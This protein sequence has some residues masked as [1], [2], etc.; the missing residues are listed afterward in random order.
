MSGIIANA[1]T[2]LKDL[3]ENLRIEGHSF[4][5]QDIENCDAVADLIQELENSVK[6][7]HSD[8]ETETI[9]TSQYRHKLTLIR[10]DLDK[11][12]EE[13]VEAARLSH[14][15]IM[16]NL[17]Q[18]L[19]DINISMSDLHS[20]DAV[21]AKGIDELKPQTKSLAA[22]HHKVIQELNKK[23]A[24]KAEAQIRVNE[25]ND[26]LAGV[27]EKIK[28]AEEAILLLKEQVNKVEKC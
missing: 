15:H 25:T 16:D 28:E 23:M 22:R 2:H 8:L 18:K 9:K 11:E 19:N 21:L 20:K 10:D 14:V 5:S 4:S 6:A 17:K 7:L 24:E 13:N 3:Q 12:I 1:I 27:N 26:V